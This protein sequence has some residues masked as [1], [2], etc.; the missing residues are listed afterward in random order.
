MRDAILP[1]L[2]IPD[3]L[4]EGSQWQV[5]LSTGETFEDPDFIENWDNG[6]NLNLFRRITLDPAV[7]LEAIGLS[8]SGASLH[9]LVW[10]GA[11]D[12]RLPTWKRLLLR[13]E[14]EASAPEIDVCLDISG[15]NLADALHLDCA[16]ILARAPQGDVF[17]LSP[18]RV[19]DILWRERSRIRLEGDVS[20]FPISETDLGAFL[21]GEWRDTLW[22]LEVEW[23]DF[24]ASFH[25]A[26]RLHLNSLKKDFLRQFR[27]GDSDTLQTVLGDVMVQIASGFL[28]NSDDLLEATARDEPGSLSAV[29]IGWIEQAFGSTDKARH[30]RTAVPGRYHAQLQALAITGEE[31]Q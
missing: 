4:V 6:T 25:S 15:E 8:V 19:G 22:Y 27:N 2:V 21:G 14:I 3:E 1:F 23:G 16:I 26:V 29:A 17:A 10:V 13:Q 28:E 11:G 31:R 30:F 5:Q 9:L 20:R 12:G 18:K 7:A 24:S